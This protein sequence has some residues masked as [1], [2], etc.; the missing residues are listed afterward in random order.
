MKFRVSLE[1]LYNSE[2]KSVPFTRKIICHQCGY[3]KEIFSFSLNRLLS[4]F[5]DDGDSAHP[6]VHTCRSEKEKLI[7]QEQFCR[8]FLCF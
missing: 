8:F 1:T 5:S 7:K 6:G 2:T 4:L 3:A